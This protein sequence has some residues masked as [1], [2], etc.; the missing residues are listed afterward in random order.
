MNGEGVRSLNSET[1]VDNVAW[2]S[3]QAVDYLI[4]CGCTDRSFFND[5]CQAICQ[6]A[7]ITHMFL[8]HKGG[9]PK[10]GKFITN[11]YSMVQFA[12]VI[13]GLKDWFP[14]KRWPW[15]KEEM[16]KEFYEEWG[17]LFAPMLLEI[18]EIQKAQEVPDIIRASEKKP[19]EKR[20]IL[21]DDWKR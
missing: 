15:S 19:E 7:V 16:H 8:Q 9:F 13:L 21:T 6:I 12:A 18:P 1:T 2:Y 4:S 5:A 11:N 20:V 14:D 10:E 17:D 3:E